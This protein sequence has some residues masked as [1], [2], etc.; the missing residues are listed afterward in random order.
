MRAVI[1]DAEPISRALL[2]EALAR[3]GHLTEVARDGLEAWR[4]VAGDD[5]PDLL[6]A[7]WRVAGLDGLELCRRVRGLGPKA[8]FVVLLAA[9]D[10]AQAMA[11]GIAAGVDDVLQ[12][13]L[14]LD[15]LELRLRLAA[16]TQTARLELARMRAEAAS[17]SRVDQL[18]GVDDRLAISSRLEAELSR[19]ARTKSALTVLLL[20]VDR[21]R[22]INDA[23]GHEAGD[24]VLVTIAARC[25]KALRRYDVV[26]RWGGEEFLLLLPGCT[27]DHAQQLADR[28]LQAIRVDTIPTSQGRVAITCSLGGICLDVGADESNNPEQVVKAVERATEEAAAAGGDRAAIFRVEAS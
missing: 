3:A 12:K 19:A 26:G 25:R 10:E 5:P 13:P 16:R 4:L 8:P 27:A 11:E 21:F 15:V 18:T 14:R 23:F 6:I 17:R 7:D 24:T 9:A 22:D 1:A 2:G 28:L 20:D